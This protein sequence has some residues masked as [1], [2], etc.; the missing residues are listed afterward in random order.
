ME[1]PEC[2]SKKVRR[3]PEK[4]EIICEKCGLIIDED[5]VAA[6]LIKFAIS[7]KQILSAINHYCATTIDCP[8]ASQHGFFSFHERTSRVTEDQAC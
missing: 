3:D 7:D 2:K 1:C 4:G 6:D 5:S 8:V